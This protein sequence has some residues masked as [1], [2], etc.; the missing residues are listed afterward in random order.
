MKIAITAKGAGLGAWLDPVFEES[1]QLVLVD[2]QGR[3]GSWAADEAASGDPHG[4]ARVGWLIAMGAG[5]LV[6]GRLTEETRDRLA[7]AGIM[8]LSAEGGSVLDL[9]EAAQH[10]LLKR[11]A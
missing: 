10:N 6:T 3:F 11:L 4:V 9:V 5:A 1:R 8:V 2:E 7:A